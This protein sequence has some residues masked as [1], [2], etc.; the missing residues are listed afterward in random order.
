MKKDNRIYA[1]GRRKTSVA[2]VFLSPNGKGA[3][4]VNKKDCTEYFPEC[5]LT[6][7]FHIKRKWPHKLTLFQGP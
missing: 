6:R 4:T 2:R 7:L 3:F 5:L 1:T